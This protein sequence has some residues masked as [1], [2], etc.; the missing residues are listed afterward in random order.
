MHRDYEF[1]EEQQNAIDSDV[2]MVLTACPGSGKTTVIVE[3]IRKQLIDMPLY[4]GVIGITFTQKAAKELKQKCTVDSFDI[5]SSFLGT[6]DNFCLKEIIY[7]FINRIYG[8]SSY[9]LECKTYNKIDA[10][11]KENLPNLDESG[12]FLTTNEYQNYENEFKLHYENGF[13]LLEAIGVLANYILNSSLSAKR[14]IKSKYISLYID[15]YQDSS[16]VQHQLFLKIHGLGLKSIAVGDI[17]QSIYEWRGGSSDHI[18]D[19]ISKDTIFKRFKVDKNHRCH[20]S[21]TN[22]SNRLFDETCEL[23]EVDEVRVYQYQI[24]GTQVDVALKLNTLIPKIMKHFNIENYSDTGILVNESKSFIYLEDNLTIPFRVY[25]DEPLLRINTLVSKL[26]YELLIYRLN[27]NILINDILE[28]LINYDF[29][30]RTKLLIDRRKIKSI[31]T[32]LDN[33]LKDKFLILSDK[34]LNEEPNDLEIEALQNIL[35][36]SE[37]L[38]NYNFQKDNELQ[39]MTLHKSK[40][41]EFKIVIHLDLY[42]WILPYQKVVNDD[43]NNPIYPSLEQNLNLH[44][45]GVTRAKNACFLIY[46]NRRFNRNDKNVSGVASHFL[47]KEGLNGLYKDLNILIP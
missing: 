5:K 40:G 36:S 44:Y 14:Y 33:E 41:L 46:S 16:E 6:I 21:I 37:L 19:L 30:N 47:D 11:F 10:E 7:P 9:K 8:K 42:E 18:L 1:T 29:T 15:E 32:C 28:S 31:R 26:F 39:I 23:L 22:Y 2:N 24:N 17:K 38:S 34:L 20:D 43:W 4:K 3:K 45:V 35:A 12:V 13:I 27:D 25:K